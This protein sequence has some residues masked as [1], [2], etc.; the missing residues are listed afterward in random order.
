MRPQLCKP[1]YE[2]HQASSFKTYLPNL[3]AFK[4]SS[5]RWIERETENEREKE[6]DRER[7]SERERKRARGRELER[8]RE[9][10]RY[11]LR[12]F[13]QKALW[14]CIFHKQGQTE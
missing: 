1:S 10:G 8:A 9:S 13:K 2:A 3:T 7:D 12:P 11:T 4:N 14:K 5:G 6:K